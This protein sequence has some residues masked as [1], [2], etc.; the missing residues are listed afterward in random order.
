MTSF[1]KG[2]FSF[3]FFSET[4][5]ENIVSCVSFCLEISKQKVVLWFGHFDIVSSALPLATVMYI[6]VYF[7]VSGCGML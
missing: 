6:A 1:F 4:K 7:I 5:F 2:R 3:S